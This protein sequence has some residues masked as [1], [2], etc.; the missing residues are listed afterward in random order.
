MT[1][2][3]NTALVGIYLLATLLLS[4]AEAFNCYVRGTSFTECYWQGDAPGCGSTDQTPYPYG[5]VQSD[6]KI[7]A[8][9]TKDTTI[10]SLCNDSPGEVVMSGDCCSNYGAG[11]WSGYK[12]LWCRDP[13]GRAPGSETT[14]ADSRGP[15]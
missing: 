15:F 6:G 7:L 3:F 11:C 12:R 1:K 10:G 8:I 4:H 2:S 5:K 13:K 9:S 14:I